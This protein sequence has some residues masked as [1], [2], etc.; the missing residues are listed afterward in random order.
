MKKFLNILKQKW[1]LF[2]LEV[3]VIMI[4]IMGAAALSNWN[5]QK[6]N[7]ELEKKYIQDIHYDFLKNKAQ[8]KSVKE[9]L[10]RGFTVADSLISVFP[11]TK[12]NWGGIIDEYWKPFMYIT[13]NPINSSVQSLITSGR[14]ELIKNYELKRLLISWPDDLGDFKAAE[15]DLKRLGN[16]RED[17]ILNEPAYWDANLPM[18]KN[19]WIKLERLLKRRKGEFGLILGKD[20]RGDNDIVTTAT[21]N[22]LLSTIDS[23]ISMTAPYID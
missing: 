8:F 18:P 11:L 4:G 10:E 9:S 13:F 21:R 14:I 17:L 22:S 5:E 19:M 3:I 1:P 16:I 6:K 2:I 20:L 12:D 15:D 7:T 23:I